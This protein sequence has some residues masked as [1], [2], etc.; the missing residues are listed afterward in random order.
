MNPEGQNKPDGQGEA[1]LNLECLRSAVQSSRAITHKAMAIVRLVESG[2][3]PPSALGVVLEQLELAD[4][5][6]G[7]E[8]DRLAR[9]RTT[10]V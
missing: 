7:S 2:E 6:V 10:S 3:K 4:R 8:L 1:D 5:L 9:V